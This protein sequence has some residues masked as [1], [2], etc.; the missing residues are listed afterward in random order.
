MAV[1]KEDWWVII[2]GLGAAGGAYWYW[3]QKNIVD[4]ANSEGEASQAGNVQQDLQYYQSIE[5]ESA[6][7]VVT[8]GQLYNPASSSNTP[9]GT[10]NPTNGQTYTLPTNS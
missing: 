7:G 9:V 4:N 2:G 10:A 8:Y 5:N 1:A 3:K 6:A